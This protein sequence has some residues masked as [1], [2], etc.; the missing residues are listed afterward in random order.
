MNFKMGAM[1]RKPVFTKTLF[2]LVVAGLLLPVAISIVVALASLL[3][4]LDDPTGGVAL[5]YVAMAGGVLW[6]VDLIAIVLVQAIDALDRPDD[7]E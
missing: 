5:R 1:R 7:E 2:G 4:K 3:S 6:I